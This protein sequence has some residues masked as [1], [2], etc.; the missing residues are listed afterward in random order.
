MPD[1]SANFNISLAS[2][3]GHPVT[4]LLAPS[5]QQCSISRTKADL[6]K[7]NWDRGV[8]IT[9]T[10]S[11]G[12]TVE[13]EQ[14][15][16]VQ[17][18]PAISSDPAYNGL[19]SDNVTVFAREGLQ[20]AITVR[21]TSLAISEPAGAAVFTI[22][23]TVQPQSTVILPVTPS[24]NQCTVSPDVTQI[25]AQNWSSGTPVTVIAVD[26][27]VVDGEQECVV[28]TGPPSGGDPRFEGLT[29]DD[30]FVKVLDADIPLP[31]EWS[32]YLPLVSLSWPPL[33]GMPVL[34]PIDNADGDGDYSVMWTTA[35]GA[36]TYAL[37][38]AGNSAFRPAVEVYAG[39]ATSYPLSG[40]TTGRYYYRVKASN[41]WG[42]SAWSVPQATDVL[43]EL[44]P[45][46]RSSE[47]N[48]ALV[49]GLDYRGR[50]QSRADEYDYYYFDLAATGAV[51][52][53]LRD[54][55]T[56]QDFN[57]VLRDAT[58]NVVGYSAWGGNANEYIRETVSSGRY[59]VQVW[60]YAGAGSSLPYLL[61]VLH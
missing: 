38:Q 55:P 3:P 41:S 53:W 31:I 43:W 6:T 21:P 12:S 25:D 22:T 9:V 56:G 42:D 15:C 32:I 4:V 14:I 24:N 17:T 48:G 47:A 60:N 34:Q 30:V 59:Y 19:Q 35:L 52:L 51:E 45:N 44:E 27:G 40:Q 61:R 26:D 54:I 37:E 18:G 1:G 7:G 49:S 33:P 13:G 8:E 28:R 57:L 10:A 11:L 20:A 50:F 29:G 39:P 36:E 46:D 2:E 16:I 58:Q 23:L 5:N